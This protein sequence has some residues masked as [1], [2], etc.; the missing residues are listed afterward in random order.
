MLFL[1]Y[2]CQMTDCFW[3]F[4]VNNKALIPY[5]RVHSLTNVTVDSV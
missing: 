1:V 3:L 4:P 2:L 5:V